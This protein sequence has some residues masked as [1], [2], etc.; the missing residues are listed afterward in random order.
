MVNIFINDFYACL[1]FTLSKSPFT[2]IFNT[3]NGMFHKELEGLHLE[4]LT[5][6]DEQLLDWLQM[7][8]IFS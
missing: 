4:L 8:V 7:I 6:T 2:A 5:M 3:K 1:N